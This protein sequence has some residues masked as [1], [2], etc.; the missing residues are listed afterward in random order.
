MLVASL[1][2]LYCLSVQRPGN[3]KM[4][5][6]YHGA[7]SYMLHLT[8]R[9]TQDLPTHPALL[10]ITF[11]ISKKVWERKAIGNSGPSCS[12]DNSILQVSS[13]ALVYTMYC[14]LGLG[15]HS[16]GAWIMDSLSVKE[17][18]WWVSIQ[19]NFTCLH[20]RNV[21]GLAIFAKILDKLSVISY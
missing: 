2:I 3:L 14:L 11:C 9:Q 19:L 8:P 12:W 17:A 13:D 20:V 15:Y 6:V 18:S 21:N 10:Y 4:S 7:P 5:I 1:S 16:I